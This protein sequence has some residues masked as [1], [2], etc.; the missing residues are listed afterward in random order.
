MGIQR[1][2]T[3]ADN[4][5][6]LEAWIQA[7]IHVL[8]FFGGVPTL[9]VPDNT[10]TAVTRACRYD[11]DLNPTYQDFVAHYGIVFPR[12]LKTH[13]ASVGNRRPYA[14]LADHTSA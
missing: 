3:R 7:H 11:L 9:V 13:K 1:Q 10:K 12:V 14:D 6:Q 8:E 5:Q 4:D 2:R